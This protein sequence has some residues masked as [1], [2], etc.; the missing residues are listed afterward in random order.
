MDLTDPDTFENGFPYEHF[1]RLRAEDPVH[2]HP[3][4]K[5]GVGFWVISR[6]ADICTI[7]KQPKL[8]TSTQGA[9]QP[10][11]CPGAGHDGPLRVGCAGDGRRETS[12]RSRFGLTGPPTQF[13]ILRENTEALKSPADQA[14][15]FLYATQP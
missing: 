2:W 14:R 12:R 4:P 10:L 8:F 13:D 3:A 9:G 6:H 1:R 5:G 11:R 7:S 15:L